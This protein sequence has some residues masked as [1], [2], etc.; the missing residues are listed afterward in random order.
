MK[1]LFMKVLATVLVSTMII[2]MYQ[3]V[4]VKSAE[5]AEIYI[6]VEDYSKAISN[7]INIAAVNDSY[8]EGLKA[9]GIIIEGEFT[10][11]DENITRGDALVIL[12]RADEY[13]NGTQVTSELVQTAIEK[14]IS[15]IDKVTEGKRVDVAKA[16]LK[17]FMKGYSN[18]AYCTDRELKVTKMITKKG[19]LSCISMLKDN[20]KRA[21]ISPDGQLIRTKN[22]PK[23]A[24]NYPYI[25]ESFPN[26]YYD[27]KFSY[28]ISSETT[29]NEKT[30]KNEKVEFVNLVDYAKP[31]DLD[32]TKDI[33]DFPNVKKVRMESWVNKA[34]THMESIFNIDYRKTGE[35]WINSITSTSL[36]SGISISEENERE[37]LAKFL[38]RAKENKTVIESSKI[39][40]DGSSMYYFDGVYYLRFYVR[41]RIVSSKTQYQNRKVYLTNDLFYTN[42]PIS[43]SNFE[44]GEW[45]ECFFDVELDNHHKE[46]PE[47]L[48]VYRAQIVED[49]YTGAIIK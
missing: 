40:T 17:G 20:S 39:A 21:K 42:Y 46:A 4:N 41:Y 5:A 24:K 18:G 3:S 36:S 33:E 43:L 11:Y 31:A 38:A 2:A 8:A 34:K 49:F 26:E 35:E 22:L 6:S 10:S 29:Y 30:G 45:K 48:G 12:S 7:E 47:N 13:L 25:L 27:W 14:R 44:L 32:L 16:Y 28:E 1:G 15:D 9:A 37:M 23:T 19:A